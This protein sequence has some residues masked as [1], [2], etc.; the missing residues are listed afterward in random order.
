M[1]LN[2]AHCGIFFLPRKNFIILQLTITL[3]SFKLCFFFGFLLQLFNLT[4]CFSIGHDFIEV[5]ESTFHNIN[6]TRSQLFTFIQKIIIKF[7]LLVNIIEINCL[8]LILFYFLFSVD[9]VFSQ[10]FLMYNY[11]SIIGLLRKLQPSFR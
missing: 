2:Y 7:I 6:I 5:M 3:F 8:W 9:M 11:V 4:S 10:L 1:T